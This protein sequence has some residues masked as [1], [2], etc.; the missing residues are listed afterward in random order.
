[1][2]GHLLRNYSRDLFQSSGS[3]DTERKYSLGKY[4]QVRS[5]L[6]AVASLARTDRN[7]KRECFIMKVL[8]SFGGRC[9]DCN[10][11]K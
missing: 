5:P 7:R 6:K 11:K 9:C 3:S 1:M 10:C 8:R 4:R 2:S